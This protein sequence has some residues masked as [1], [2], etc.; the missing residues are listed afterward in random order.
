MDRTHFDSA[1]EAFRERTRFWPYTIARVNGDRVEVDHSDALVVRDGVAI[2]VAP[3][4]VPLVFD[5][6]G[7]SQIVGDLSAADPGRS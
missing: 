2:Y 4:G 1:L 7:V 3:G 6:E 5:H